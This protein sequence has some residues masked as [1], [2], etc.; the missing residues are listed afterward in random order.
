MRGDR[1]RRYSSREAGITFPKTPGSFFTKHF[2]NFVPPSDAGRKIKPP[3]LSAQARE[4]PMLFCGAVATGQ[5]E[6]Y[7][8]ARPPERA[9][10]PARWRTAT[11]CAPLLVAGAALGR[12]CDGKAGGPTALSDVSSAHRGLDAFRVQSNLIGSN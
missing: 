7:G 8:I 2:L 10:T 6:R 1:D 9:A 11:A 4:A 3:S 12:A 5:E